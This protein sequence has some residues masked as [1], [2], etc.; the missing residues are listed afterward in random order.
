MNRLGTRLLLAMLV[1]ATVSLTVVP[2]AHNV[3]EQVTLGRLQAEF[4]QRVIDRTGPM[5]FL[6][7]PPPNR[8]SAA[9]GPATP[10]PS[11]QDTDEASPGPSA[12]TVNIPDL[13]EENLR[14]FTL[15]GDLRAAQRRAVVSGVAI[16]LFICAVLALWLSRSIA[17]PLEAVSSAASA[18]AGGDLTTRVVTP[19][20]FHPQEA[21][22]LAD[23]FNSM[24][25]SLERAE[26][27][28]KAMLADVAH[29]LRTPLAALSIRL[30]ALE[31]GLVPFSTGEAKLLQGHTKLLARLIDDLRLLSLA[32]AGRLTLNLQKVNLREWLQ[33]ATKA[34]DDTLLGRG[35]RLVARFP[36]NPVIVIADP[37]RLTQ[38][39]QN[40]IDN[41]TK[42]TPA[43]RLVQI[44]LDAS[45]E[46]ALMRVRDEGPGIP[47]DE[48]DSI[49][50][51]FVQ[52]RRRD[53]HGAGG[54]GLGL[55]I[56]RTLITLHG[57]HVT[58]SNHADGAEVL[59]RLPVARST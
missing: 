25:G 57:G 16:A 27:E 58:A 26:G 36:T 5:P 3:A 34:Y 54:S 46:E 42:V 12:N 28:R 31:E 37:Q 41:A 7:A 56:V 49:F 4:R 32:D 18:L 51:R 44:T 21:R 40:L 30:E 8:R 39:L 50:E 6:G 11:P 17:R 9:P 38:I 1:V 22:L 13:Q 14:L 35:V 45:E 24:A 19:G 15:F 33:Q 43:G 52:G 55:A 29:E 48:L 10:E 59:V 20:A 53:T 47:E 23:G 2:I